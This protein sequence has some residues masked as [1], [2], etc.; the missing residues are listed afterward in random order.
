MNGRLPPPAAKPASVG[1]S[2][3]SP[4]PS[5]AAESLTD[6]FSEHGPDAQK[7]HDVSQ[8]DDSDAGSSGCCSAAAMRRAEFARLDG[9]VYADHAGTTLYTDRQL[10]EVYQ[11]GLRTY[12]LMSAPADSDRTSEPTTVVHPRTRAVLCYGTD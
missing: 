3:R 6:S 1:A 7:T 9:T 11:V 4:A 2:S 5:V 12:D 8:S 10:Q